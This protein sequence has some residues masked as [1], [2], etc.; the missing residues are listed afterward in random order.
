MGSSSPRE[1]LRSL[2]E[3]VV[4]A[5]HLDLEEIEVTPAGRRRLLRVVVDGDGGVDLDQVALVSQAVSEVL[6]S[7][8]AMGS[9]PYVLEVTS[10]GVGRPLTEPRHWRR[11]RS[12][13]VRVSLA[14]G[15]VVAGRVVAADEKTATLDVGG[16]QR[17]LPYVEVATARVE[18]EFSRPEDGHDL[19][20]GSDLDGG[21]G[22]A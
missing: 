14:A 8:D 22:E 16:A 17:R 18:V 19:D 10:P 7:S 3:P 9:S 21:A 1:R 5:Q 20:G 6:D 4:T 15:G 2:L 12:R 13:L 11:A